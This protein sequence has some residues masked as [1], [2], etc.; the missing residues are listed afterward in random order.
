MR[1]LFI[2]VWF[3]ALVLTVPAYAKPAMSM[4]SMA[5]EQLYQYGRATYDRSNYPEAAKIF[6]RILVMDPQH[7]GAL[8]YA[9]KLQKK[10]QNVVIPVRPIVDT[11]TVATEHDQKPQEISKKTVSPIEVKPNP[12]LVSHA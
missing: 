8:D 1:K 10:G 9:K 6:S 4:R 2:T 11:V 7:E 12:L 3:M 5:V